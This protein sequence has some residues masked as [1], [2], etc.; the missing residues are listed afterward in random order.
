MT[1]DDVVAWSSLGTAIFTLGLVVVALI[2]WRT[3]KKTLEASIRA[4]QAAEAANEQ[5]RLDSIEQTRP[6]VYVEVLP[7]LAGH[8]SFDL[9]I[10][11]AG[12]SSAREMTLSHSDWPEHPDDVTS[13][14]RTLFET[15][16]SLP[17]GCSL[18]TMWSLRGDFTDGTSEAGVTTEGRVT[19][20]Y[21]SDDPSRPSYVDAY[22]IAPQKAGLWPVPE[23]GPNPD[24]VKG[25]ALRFYRLG[26]ALV[27]SVGEISR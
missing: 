4:S 13:S 24:G 22:D 10:T 27:R 25:P 16:R 7:G 9:R 15:P 12:R 1:T 14:I 18:R 23:D 19:V 20:S 26:Q 5:A 3:A 11:N 8:G 2:A 21:T 6:Y 17:P